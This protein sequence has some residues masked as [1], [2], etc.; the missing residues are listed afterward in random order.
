MQSAQASPLDCTPQHARRSGLPAKLRFPACS[1]PTA[2]RWP[3][4]PG[5]LEQ[6][7]PLFHCSARSVVLRCL[8]PDAAARGHLKSGRGFQPVI[9]HRCQQ[10]RKLSPGWGGR[11]GGR[12]SPICCSQWHPSGCPVTMA[13][14][15]ARGATSGPLGRIFLEG[16]RRRKRKWH[17]EG[18]VEAP[19]SKCRRFW[20]V[21]LSRL[22]KAERLGPPLLD[23]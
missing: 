20:K 6:W 1:L 16:S 9:Y 5:V 22:H 23:W 14:R 21:L 17:V 18:P 3:E 2:S 11:D 12:A 15:A 13:T 19:V 10:E 8:E 7:V 4:R